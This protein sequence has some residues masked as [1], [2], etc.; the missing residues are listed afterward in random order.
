MPSLH[1]RLSEELHA[2]LVA[3]A[4]AEHRS[5][6]AEVIHRLQ[7]HPPLARLLTGPP[8]AA[9]EEIKEASPAEPSVPGSPRARRTDKRAGMCPHR[10]PAGSFCKTCDS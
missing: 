7:A 1:V 5:L 4:H 6:Q 10:V 8:P 2:E 9:L 3:A